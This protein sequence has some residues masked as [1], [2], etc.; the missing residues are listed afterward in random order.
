MCSLLFCGR[1]VADGTP[2][3]SCQT[4]LN[5]NYKGGELC[6]CGIDNVRQWPL[7]LHFMFASPQEPES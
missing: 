5:P 2:A 6:C 1:Y 4:S 7:H 3:Y